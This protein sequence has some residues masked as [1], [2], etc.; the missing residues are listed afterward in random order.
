MEINGKLQHQEYRIKPDYEAAYM[1]DPKYEKSIL[2]GEEINRA[3][4][5]ITAMSHHLDLMKTKFSAVWYNPVPSQAFG[6][7][8]GYGSRA[9][10]YMLGVAIFCN[11]TIQFKID[12]QFF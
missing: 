7:G 9:S 6:K 3:Y 5:F 11:L 12:S 4:T 10:T 1:V 2:S 8:M